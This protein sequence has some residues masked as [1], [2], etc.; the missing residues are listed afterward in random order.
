MLLPLF[1]IFATYLRRYATID[2]RRATLLRQQAAALRLFRATL[3]PL[4]II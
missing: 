2:A 3:M 4:L 1:T